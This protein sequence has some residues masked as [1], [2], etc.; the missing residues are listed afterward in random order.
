LVEQGNDIMAIATIR[1]PGLLAI[2]A[3]CALPGC[4]ATAPGSAGS[5]PAGE[6]IAVSV[7]PCFGFCP[8]YKAS[9]TPA[10]TVTFV[11]ERHTAVIGTRTREAG[12]ATQAEIATTLAV[13]RPTTG[14]T[15]DTICETRI[16]DQQHYTLTWTAANGAT[17]VLNH[18]KG[19]RSA[20]ND[21]LNAALQALP[22]R[23]G[24]GDWAQQTT[25][26]GASRG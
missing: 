2:A 19:C 8:V 24:I 12:A 18:D 22:Q 15:T 4:A 6:T 21:A 17:T 11:G 9:V 5:S 1:R 3:L 7:G 10:G 20:Q 14:A 26:P 23:L 13:F 16:S 25:R